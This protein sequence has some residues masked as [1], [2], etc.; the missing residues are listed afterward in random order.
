MIA[1]LVPYLVATCQFQGEA[2]EV[3]TFSDTHDQLK[4]EIRHSGSGEEWHVQLTAAYVE[5]LT[6]KTGNFKRFDTFCAMIQSALSQRSSALNLD[7]VSYDDLEALRQSKLKSR[8]LNAANS[9][10]PLKNN[11][12]YMILSYVTEFDKIHYPIPLTYV[13]CLSIEACRELIRKLRAKLYGEKAHVTKP[14]DSLL[15]TDS[16]NTILQLQTQNKALMQEL[17]ML[18]SQVDVY[19][20]SKMN[21]FGDEF[22]EFGVPE[23]LRVLVNNLET[24]L[25]NEKN[26][27][28]RQIIEYRRE[29]ARLQA[30]LSSSNACQRNMSRRIEQLTNE[31]AV[32]KRRRPPCQQETR[33]FALGIRSVSAGLPH[34]TPHMLPPKNNYDRSHQT[35]HL[36]RR[37]SQLRGGSLDLAQMTRNNNAVHPDSIGASPSFV[38]KGFSQPVRRAGSA[39]P[40]LYRPTATPLCESIRYRLNSIS[41]SREPSPLSF[42]ASRSP[43][44]RSRSCSE[45][46]TAHGYEKSTH[47]FDP[48]AYVRE[49][50]RQKQEREM[51]RQAE[52]QAQL[53]ANTLAHGH[54]NLDPWRSRYTPSGLSHDTRASSMGRSPGVMAVRHSDFLSPA[55]SSSCDSLASRSARPSRERNRSSSHQSGTLR[56]APGGYCPRLMRQTVRSPNLQAS[57]PDDSIFTPSQR[58]KRGSLHQG[59]TSRHRNRSPSLL[60]NRTSPILSLQNSVNSVED[61]SDIDSNQSSRLQESKRKSG[62]ASNR[63]KK[64]LRLGDRNDELEEIDRRLNVLQDFFQKYLNTA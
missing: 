56:V 30:E 16:G 4:I 25:L 52:R 51:K 62:R 7:L 64:P 35:G 9:T 17:E 53:S 37:D 18:R 43:L 54:T 45:D 11:R 5:E 42:R 63:P 32:F 21:G 26:K 34:S 50:Q 28:S 15:T 55:L 6:R 49:R 33:P 46:R 8:I 12:Y 47:R 27:N 24:E 2:Y 60:N 20:R 48:T 41:R 61:G 22:R 36:S 57:S 3:E 44:S 40:H 29:V 39:S 59:N 19:E 10:I 1:A 23:E 13:G 14:V 31:L 58:H 38:P